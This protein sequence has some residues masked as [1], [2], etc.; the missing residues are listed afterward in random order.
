MLT[1]GKAPIR[2]ACHEG[3]CTLD[4]RAPTWNRHDT[5]AEGRGRIHDHRGRQVRQRELKVGQHVLSFIAL[6]QAQAHAEL[7]FAKRAK[8]GGERLHD[9]RA[10]VTDGSTAVGMYLPRGAWRWKSWQVD[11]DPR[12][13]KELD[14]EGLVSA[15]RSR[16]RNGIAQTQGSASL[17]SVVQVHLEPALMEA[18]QS[19]CSGLHHRAQVIDVAAPPRDRH[20]KRLTLNVRAPQLDP[21]GWRRLDLGSLARARCWRR[22]CRRRTRATTGR[23]HHDSRPGR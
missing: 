17:R 20:P 11:P 12:W 1:A 2:N 21:H 8:L 10:E 23:G 3:H 22:N 19:W 14:I 7:R 6:L 18:A 9:R 13:D 4:A 16:G 5:D 15:L